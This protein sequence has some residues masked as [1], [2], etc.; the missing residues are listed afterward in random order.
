MAIQ[1]KILKQEG[2]SIDEDTRDKVTSAQL[3]TI[4]T[5]YNQIEAIVS[6]RDPA[7]LYVKDNNE[8]RKRCSRKRCSGRRARERDVRER[9]S[10]CS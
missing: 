9:D 7:K 6:G 1:L 2:R 10:G 3:A 4:I 5:T 8:L